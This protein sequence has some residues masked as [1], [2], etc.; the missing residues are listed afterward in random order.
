MTTLLLL[1]YTS[2]LFLCFYICCYQKDCKYATEFKMIIYLFFFSKISSHRNRFLGLSTFLKSLA[3]ILYV[4]LI[5]VMKKTVKGKSTKSTENGK[6][7]LDDANLES[8]SSNGRSAPSAGA[9]GEAH[10]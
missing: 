7:A 9:D 6:K 2:V 8:L 1:I 4:V 5:S 10:I 3:L